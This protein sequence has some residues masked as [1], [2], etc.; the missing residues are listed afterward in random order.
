VHIV[1]TPEHAR[2][3]IDDKT[4]GTAPYRAAIEAGMHS[5][6]IEADGHRSASTSFDVPLKSQAT[7]EVAMTLEKAAELVPSVAVTAPSNLAA[8]PSDATVTPARERTV[9]WSYVVG[10]GAVAAGVLL[11]I[12]PIRTLAS[13]GDCIGRT[14]AAGRC[15]ERVKVGAGSIAL[16]TTGALA[17]IG[18]TAVCVATPIR[19]EVAP[20][21]AAA[22]LHFAL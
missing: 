16:L 12:A 11:A 3:V 9:L 21:H 10:G 18:G 13:N 15:S 17:I 22:A 1:T 14:D 6:R 4:V 7:V 8:P 20:D 2:V 5:L 19:I